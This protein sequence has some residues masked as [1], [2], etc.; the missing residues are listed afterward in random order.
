MGDRSPVGVIRFIRLDKPVQALEFPAIVADGSKRIRIF[1]TGDY[2]HPSTSLT[3]TNHVT[4]QL[5]RDLA[6]PSS[7]RRE[8]GPQTFLFT[9][10]TVHQLHN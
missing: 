9:T 2:F 7:A 5:D 3:A 4:C 1:R 10:R 6:R 8:A